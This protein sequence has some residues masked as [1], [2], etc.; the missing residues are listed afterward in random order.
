MLHTGK[1]YAFEY[2][3]AGLLPST[4]EWRTVARQVRK[5]T[6]PV[7]SRSDT[8]TIPP[9]PD[10][11]L[12]ALQGTLLD[13]FTRDVHTHILHMRK[14]IRDG[15]LQKA[16]GLR[17]TLQHMTSWTLEDLIQGFHTLYARLDPA[18]AVHGHSHR[19]GMLFTALSPL[20][21]LGKQGL[22]YYALGFMHDIGKLLVPPD[23][24]KAKRRLNDAEWY[25]IQLHPW[26][27]GVILGSLPRDILH[28][29]GFLS[30][31]HHENWDGSGYPYALSWRDIQDAS[32]QLP[33]HPHESFSPIH[34]VRMVSLLR[35]ADSLEA[36]LSKKYSPERGERAYNII[37]PTDADKLAAYIQ[38]DLT[39]RAGSWY[40]PSMVKQILPVLPAVQAAYT[41][42][43]ETK[44]ILILP[45]M[46][47]DPAYENLLALLSSHD[48]FTY[49][50]SSQQILLSVPQPSSS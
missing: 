2:A 26:L 34:A 40:D 20:V 46:E 37:I 39:L 10:P 3:Q 6:L 38:E 8:P 42:L 5:H 45:W 49:S 47:A 21:G 12:P 18:D 23:I 48:P 27:G 11:E 32:A 4:A 25:L 41:R 50:S 22:S 33:L 14:T 36:I 16:F 30:L 29:G 28:L 7:P 31:Y 19:V 35:I 24:L 44:G 13:D 1:P 9:P 17:D 43:A 15:L